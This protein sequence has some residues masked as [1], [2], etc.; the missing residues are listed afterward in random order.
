MGSTAS[1]AA[2]R[3]VVRTSLGLVVAAF[4]VATIAV[5]AWDAD[6]GAVAGALA[7]VFTVGVYAAVTAPWWA[8]RV[9]GSSLAVFWPSPTAS[10]VS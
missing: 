8:E 4:P 7:A 10:Q 2:E 3:A 5:H 9:W 6:R 1:S